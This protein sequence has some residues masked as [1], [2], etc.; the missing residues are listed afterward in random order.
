[1]RWALLLFPCLL[2]SGC[3]A[4]PIA[5][6][7]VKASVGIGAA[8]G[9][10]LPRD[11]DG[12]PLSTSEPIVPGRIGVV[13]QSMWPEQNRRPV[14][15]E[16]GYAFQVFTTELRQNR[17]RHGGFLGVSVLAG[18][19]WLGE[20]WRARIV[21]RGAGELYAMQAHAGWGGGGSWGLGFE[22]AQFT[23]S[24][25]DSGSGARFVG[26]VAGEWGVG[27]ELLGGVYTMSGAEYGIAAFAL[28]VRWPG[29][30]G[31]AIVPLTGSF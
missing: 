17:N 8:I 1:M 10:P 4:L 6:P 14:E 15:V 23:S 28:T 27:A 22:I 9:N 31:V 24:S 16:L 7:P 2:V 26:Y 3:L 5:L 30:A 18:H 11:D 29:L 20:N 12:T 21:I 19:F 25:G 13:I